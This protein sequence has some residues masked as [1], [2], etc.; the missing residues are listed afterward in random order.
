M[1]ISYGLCVMVLLCYATRIAFAILIYHDYTNDKYA[2]VRSLM[3]HVVEL[4]FM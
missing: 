1:I 4:A 3:N 2:N